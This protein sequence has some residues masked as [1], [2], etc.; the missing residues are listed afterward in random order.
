MSPC[1]SNKLKLILKTF[2]SCTG[3]D[4]NVKEDFK[5]VIRQQVLRSN[6]NVIELVIQFIDQEHMNILTNL[7]AF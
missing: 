7:M 4:R 3:A 6:E 5:Q 1:E 2:I